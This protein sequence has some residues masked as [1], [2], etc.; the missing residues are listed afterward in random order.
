MHDWRCDNCNGVLL[1]ISSQS[2]RYNCIFIP[3]LGDMI[4]LKEGDTGS[5]TNS[6]KDERVTH[7]T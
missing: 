1:K 6:E 5:D 4:K 7:R 2:F 3:K